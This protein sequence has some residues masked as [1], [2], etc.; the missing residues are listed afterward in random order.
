MPVTLSLSFSIFVVFVVG[1]LLYVAVAE[2]LDVLVR[3][4][5]VLELKAGMHYAEL[6]TQPFFDFRLDRFDAAPAR[7]CQHH[8]TV[9][10]CFVF[11]HLPEMNVMHVL[12]TIHLGHR[13]DHCTAI[14]VG[15]AAEHQRTDRLS[16]FGQGE[17]ENVEGNGNRDRRIDPSHVVENDQRP[18]DDHRY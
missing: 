13:P 16:D 7:L 5:D 8:V 11:L 18:P 3:V 12:D 2:E 15:G 10:R 14:H 17:V 4:V 1:F 6:R 9:E